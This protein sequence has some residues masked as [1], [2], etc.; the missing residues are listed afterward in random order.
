[1]DI[2]GM[3][4]PIAPAATLLL[5]RD[6][7]TQL[8]VLMLRREAAL[9]FMGGMW[10]FPGGRVDVSDCTP[11]AAAQVAESPATEPRLRALD[12]SPLADALAL[13]LRIAAC[14][15]TYEEA[16]ILLV[17]QRDGRGPDRRQ[18]DALQAERERVVRTPGTFTQLLA[19]AGLLLDIGRLV[20][21]GHW[22]TP[23]QERIRFDTRFFAAGTPEGQSASADGQE[24]TELEWLTPQDACRAAARGEMQLA[25]PTLLTLEDLDE[26]YAR[27]G[28]VDALL[29]AERGRATP[30][31]LP[32][33]RTE[34][35][36]MHVLMPW[37][38]AYAETQGEGPAPAAAYP[39]HLTRRRSNLVFERGAPA[40]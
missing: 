28:S 9:R 39:P 16:G 37:D 30:P 11:A 7:G 38:P 10:V 14:R 25:P 18:L 35:A 13:G 34:G 5:L 40:R 23:S 31:V 1:L 8:E 27:H 20:S 29:N 6:R 15:E 22:I 24:S 17:R 12:G 3:A 21:W 2:A 19:D 26:A 36:T 33:I 32:R 4:S